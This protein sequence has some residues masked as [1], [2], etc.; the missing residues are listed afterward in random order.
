LN[1]ADTAWLTDEL[2]A[3]QRTARVLT[4]SAR[5]DLGGGATGMIA[6]GL[7]A[8]AT[9]LATAIIVSG[10]AMALLALV[11]AV[12]FMERNFH[13][14][15]EKR[16]SAAYSVFLRGASLSR[17]DHEILL[18]FA[19]TLVINA[20]FMVGWLYPKQLVHLGFP[21]NSVLWYTALFALSS[22][23]GVLALHVVEAHID[24]EGGARRFYALACLIGGLGLVVVAVAPIALIGSLGVLL[25]K[26]I[27]ESVTR[28]ISII[29]V[30]RC[31]VSE[32][33]TTVHS[34][35]S[36]AESVGEVSGGFV[37]AAVA[38]ARGVPITLTA[39]AAV[40][41]GLGVIVMRSRADRAPIP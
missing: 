38:Q 25:A 8:W 21:N 33:R 16:W 13:G 26:G 18:M 12:T 15:D 2:N 27:A 35:L 14:T 31:T 32:V 4:A 30:N 29:W 11:V 24:R 36:Q 22:A 17:R 19:A 28:P 5:R 39:A 41:T 7:L 20:A 40:I 10:L 37:L 6:F 3:P 23:I 1:G 34:F 9:S